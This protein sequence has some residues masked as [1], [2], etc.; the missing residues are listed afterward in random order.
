[1]NN[2]QKAK[3]FSKNEDIHI[4]HFLA[5]FGYPIRHY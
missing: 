1:M 4:T 2:N 5:D 3:K